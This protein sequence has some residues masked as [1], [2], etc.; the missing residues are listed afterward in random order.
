MIFLLLTILANVGIFVI[1]Q[2]LARYRVHTF[3]AIIFNYFT[4]VMTG[5]LYHGLQ[6]FQNISLSTPWLWVAI[7]L[8]VIFIGTFYLMALT[9]QRAGITVAS[10]A[11]KMSLV[12]PV[13]FTLLVL[14][15][16]SKAFDFLN[17]L[18]IFL[19]CF[20]IVFSSIKREKVAGK[21]QGWLALLLPG[22]VF[23]LSGV[24]DTSINFSSARLIQA[25]E[26]GVFPVVIFSSAF[27]I[28]LGSLVIRKEKPSPRAIL[29]GIGL[30]VVN[31]FSIYFLILTLGAFQ[32][33]GAMVYPILNIGI[34][35][36]SALVSVIFYAEKLSVLNKIGLLLAIAAIILISYQEVFSL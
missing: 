3:H 2:L 14:G 25:G 24:I 22:G 4:C 35:L 26:E 28:G 23:L 30:G 6:P 11:T 21:R 7:F 32:N 1:F 18:G 31:Y 8:G 34:I 29:F 19:G 15:T 12:I 33:D 5:L 17:Y 13:L 10:I 36:V 9:T 16:Q 27:L 20:A